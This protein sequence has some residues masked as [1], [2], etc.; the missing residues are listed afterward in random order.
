MIQATVTRRALL[1][2]SFACG[3]AALARPLANNETPALYVYP[4]SSSDRT[5]LAVAL[6]SIQI[7]RYLEVRIHAGQVSWTLNP[8]SNPDGRGLCAIEISN[9]KLE[10]SG[11][12]G[13]WGEVVYSFG[14]RRRIPSPLV[15][16]LLRENT[17]LAEQYHSIQPAEDKAKLIVPVTKMIARTARA[18]GGCAAPEK[19]AQRLAAVLFPDVLYYDPKQPAGFSFAA[20][21]GRHPK[22][23]TDFL[24]NA[25]LTGAIDS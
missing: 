13:F 14:T 2:G 23:P 8:S 9:G 16:P 11:M 10:Q 21:N 3:M 17:S 6:P 5:V 15:A 1:G 20:Q 24:V 7:K 19:Y 12:T 4:A 22:D 18:S 25:M